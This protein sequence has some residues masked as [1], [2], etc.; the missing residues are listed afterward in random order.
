MADVTK[1]V[2][3]ANAALDPILFLEN[4]RGQVMLA[5]L[6]LSPPLSLSLSLCVCVCVCVCVPR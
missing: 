5:L 4:D 6:S 1:W 3:W 2:V